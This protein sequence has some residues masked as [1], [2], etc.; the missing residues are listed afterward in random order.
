MPGS[1][2]DNLL[3]S[4]SLRRYQGGG[5]VVGSIPQEM[6]SVPAVS[7]Q[8]AHGEIDKLLVDT[9]KSSLKDFFREAFPDED[10]PESTDYG[11]V[12]TQL[13]EE[14][15]SPVIKQIRGGEWESLYGQPLSS[16][17]V[18]GGWFSQ[19][20]GSPTKWQRQGSFNWP[21]DTLYVSPGDT[22]VLLE[23]LAHQQ[24]YKKADM[25]PAE[26][27]QYR[28]ELNK[29]A[30]AEESLYG[31]ERRYDVP[32]TIEYEAHTEISPSIRERAMGLFRRYLPYQ[33]GGE[34]VRESLP[35]TKE[36][37]TDYPVG[38]KF[39][40]KGV[41]SVPA[42]YVGGTEDEGKRYYTYESPPVDRSDFNF[43]RQN[44]WPT[45]VI[46]KAIVM[47]EDSLSSAMIEG[48]LAQPSPKRSGLGF[49]KKLLKR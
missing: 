40:Y 3:T 29:R 30:A 26:L 49:L 17:R 33:A 45:S 37:S 25:A 27:E 28:A 2:L 24:Q 44:L 11:K 18:P 6:F 8:Y 7:T 34:V 15:G 20:V 47:P 21:V 42:Q 46:R 48:F 35:M 4:A 12:L 16:G 9:Q 39:V 10:S 5:G 23:E 38:D 22:D 36:Y 14:S 32:G 41:S 31:D 43:I 13:V 1:N 19:D